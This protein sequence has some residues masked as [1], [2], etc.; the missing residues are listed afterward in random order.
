MS[1]PLIVNGI[2]FRLLKF[3]R[4]I[5]CVF[6][7]FIASDY[8]CGIFKLFS[9]PLLLNKILKT[10]TCKNEN[11]KCLQVNLQFRQSYEFSFLDS[12]CR[13]SRTWNMATG[14]GLQHSRDFGHYKFPFVRICDVCL[15]GRRW[16]SSCSCLLW[17]LWYNEAG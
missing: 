4:C 17:M 3:G 5:V 6:F 2:F 14:E 7:G 13:C 1:L 11:I 8:A 9:L 12:W 15:G 10:L 16:I